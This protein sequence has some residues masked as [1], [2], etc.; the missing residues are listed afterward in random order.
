MGFALSVLVSVWGSGKSSGPMR[1]SYLEAAADTDTT[2]LKYPFHDRYGDPYSA[3]GNQSPMYLK[4]PANIKTDVQYDPDNNR[5][6]INENM[7]SLFYRNPSYMTFDEFVDNEYHNSTREYWKQRAGEDDA[8]NKKAFA[9]KIMVNSV[10]F[11]R[12]FG[13]NTI[14]IRPQGSA[15]LSFGINISNSEN[16]SIPTQ[17]RR[18]STFDFKE[19]IQM[20]IIANIGDK[21]KLTTNYNTEATFDFENK[22]KIEYTGYEDDIIKKIEAGNITMPLNSQL[23]QG[24]QS[25]F[26]IKTQLQFGRLMVTSLF[27][28]Q[29][30]KPETINVQGGAQSTTFDI[31]ADQYEENKHFFLSQFFVNS[32]DQTLRDLNHIGSSVNITKLEVWVTTR[33]FISSQ[34]NQNRNIFAFADLGEYNPDPSQ[35]FVT[36]GLIA[37]PSDSSNN[38]FEQLQNN[39]AGGTSALRRISNSSWI[40]ASPAAALNFTR[41]KNY[42]TVENARLLQPSEYTLNNRLGYISLNSKLRSNDVLAVAF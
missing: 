14:D 31:K 20:N 26:G 22:M 8:L 23:I 28:Q 7:G 3:P 25:L 1:R 35:T 2:T 19:K 24:S 38:L 29:K 10:I 27:S 30:G 33:G 32:Y 15:E 16:P 4:D 36:S 34:N 41:P 17:Q 39:V 13:G 21:M 40:A 42:E 11:D 5:Y 12:I 9:P 18:V 6:N 37:Y